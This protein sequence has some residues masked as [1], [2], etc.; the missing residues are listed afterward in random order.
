MADMQRRGDPLGSLAAFGS[1]LSRWPAPAAAAARRALLEEPRFR[2]AWE[3]ERALDG[4]IERLRDELD[5]EIGAGGALE[6]LRDGM[7]AHL[8]DQ[9]TAGLPWRRIAAGMVLAAVLGGAVDHVL[10]DDPARWSE[11][12]LVDP[13][14]AA[15]PISFE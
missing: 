2:Q 11:L 3:E 8:R 15:D 4:A 9:P 13:L 6:R 7:L 10:A 12:A 1:N 14:Y 5:A